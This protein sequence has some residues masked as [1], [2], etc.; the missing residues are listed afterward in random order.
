MT[1]MW[2]RRALIAS[3]MASPF[4]CE[5]AK[6]I[7]PTPDIIA[8]EA[9]PF[10]AAAYKG[11]EPQ[12][13]DESGPDVMGRFDGVWIKWCPCVYVGD[14]YCGWPNGPDVEA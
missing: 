8:P 14:P 11:R 3:M 10:D 13:I 9:E 12:A 7:E 6:A 2:N 1:T 4:V 5:A